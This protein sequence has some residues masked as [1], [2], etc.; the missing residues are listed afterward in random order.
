V[1]LWLLKASWYWYKA[2]TVEVTTGDGGVAAWWWRSRKVSRWW[3]SSAIAPWYCG[4]RV[5]TD[6]AGVVSLWHS[7]CVWCRSSS[8]GS[9]GDGQESSRDGE[10]AEL[11][12][13]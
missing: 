7:S 11:H 5:V 12:D 1:L 10:D 3:R 6:L 2:T 4:V 13:V 9:G 8:D